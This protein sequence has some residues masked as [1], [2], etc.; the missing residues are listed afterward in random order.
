[1]GI[2]ARS[3]S[4]DPE[5]QARKAFLE[6]N[7]VLAETTLEMAGFDGKQ[8][9]E[10]YGKCYREKAEESSAKNPILGGSN[11]SEIMESPKSKAPYKPSIGI[12]LLPTKAQLKSYRKA[13]IAHS[14]GNILEACQILYEGVYG[15]PTQ[16][17]LFESWRGWNQR[18]PVT[19]RTGLATYGKELTDETELEPE[20]RTDRRFR[21]VT[22][23]IGSGLLVAGA[24]IAAGSISYQYFKPYFSQQV[25][26]QRPAQTVQ[27][28]PEAK[29][30][31]P[32]REPSAPAAPEQQKQGFYGPVVPPAA[33]PGKTEPP[34][35]KAQE[36]AAPAPV[37]SQPAPAARPVAPAR[38]AP[39]QEEVVLYFRDESG[40]KRKI[41]ISAS[42]WTVDRI[43]IG[44][45]ENYPGLLLQT[46]YDLNRNGTDDHFEPR[47]PMQLYG[48]TRQEAEETRDKIGQCKGQDE[49]VY[50]VL[51]RSV[52]PQTDRNHNVLGI[53]VPKEY[54]KFLSRGCLD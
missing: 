26:I 11:G 24:L 35:A 20:V 30:A 5:T 7:F 51:D 34:R 32:K 13:R 50:A 48:Y 44:R 25:S 27:Q 49:A 22:R 36:P 53:K 8:I 28:K 52:H 2:R 17:E 19:E 42:R 16:N 37:P 1:M 14:K 18:K 29:P 3:G 10:F 39:S 43:D 23:L 15:E 54:V 31:A 47:L 6:D 33:Q 4:R 38:P 12:S 21:Y 45:D 40:A 41:P 46:F 9:T